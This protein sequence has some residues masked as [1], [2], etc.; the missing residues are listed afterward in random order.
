[1]YAMPAITTIFPTLG[2]N[3]IAEAATVPFVRNNHGYLVGGRKIGTADLA[4]M[5][6]CIRA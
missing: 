6:N 4:L 3:N 5:I 2:N 1:M